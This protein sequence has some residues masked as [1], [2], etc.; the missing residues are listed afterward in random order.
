[1]TVCRVTPAVPDPVLVVELVTST[2]STA[3]VALPVAISSLAIRLAS[4]DGMAK[5]MPMLPDWVCLAGN[6]QAAAAGVVAGDGRVDADHRAVQVHQ[7]AAGVAG[8][9]GGVGLH[10]VEHGLVVV[11]GAHRPG[12][13]LTMPLVTVSDR[14]SGAPTATTVWPTLSEDDLAKVAGVRLSSPSTL[15]TARSS[16]VSRPTILPGGGTAVGEHHLDVAGTVG[17]VDHVVVGQDGAVGRG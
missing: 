11:A 12:R 15:I 9:D 7:R 13:L 6:L 1:M 2:P 8:V 16:E 10:R 3:W 17:D 4:S 5:P 14:P